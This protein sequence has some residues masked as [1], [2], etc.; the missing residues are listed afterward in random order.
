MCV[1]LLLLL[2]NV[3]DD[4]ECGEGILLYRLGEGRFACIL[5]K[6]HMQPCSPALN[7]PPEQ[8]GAERS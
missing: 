8:G 5:G 4:L 2:Q 7:A 6:H 1:A 3:Y